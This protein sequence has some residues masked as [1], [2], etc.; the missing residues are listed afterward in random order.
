MKLLPLT[1]IAGLAQ[2][3]VG[4]LAAADQV[5]LAPNHDATIY[6]DPLGE[7]AN[8]AGQYLF[9]GEDG[10]GG[11]KRA[12]L[13]FDLSSIPPG[14]TIQQA[15]LKLTVSRAAGVD[16]FPVSLKRLTSA[17][18]E[19]PTDADGE[20]GG[21]SPPA[22]GDCTWIHT[23]YDTQSW[24]TPGGD[25]VAGASCTIGVSAV[26]PQT[27]TFGPTAGMT[28][29]VQGWLNAPA[30]NFG[31]MLIGDESA[32]A[33]ARRFNSRENP[34]PATRPQLIVNYTP[35]AQGCYANCDHSTAVPF[36]NVQDFS[37]FL[38]KY[39]AGDPYANCDGSTAV[40]ALNV[41]DFSCFLTR[42]ASGCSAP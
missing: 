27:C 4:S 29:D 9:A 11:V 8:G 26:S 23:Y 28:A 2:V 7:F 42:Y 35:P 32:T 36:L 10:A 40:P 37:C 19:G 25:F 12:P 13:S 17:W 16:T 21:G 3:L 33:T 15:S 6:L 39:A 34:D 24:A 14:S 1:A 20:E 30:T 31:W 18:N 5:T 41:Q 22:S 38:A